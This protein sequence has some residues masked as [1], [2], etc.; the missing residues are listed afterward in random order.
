VR[1]AEMV[2]LTLQPEHRAALEGARRL[3]INALE[4]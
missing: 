2:T 4:G 1:P 3:V